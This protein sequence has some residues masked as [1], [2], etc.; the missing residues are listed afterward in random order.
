MMM[1]MMMM[2]TISHA[3]NKLVTLLVLEGSLP[4]ELEGSTQQNSKVQCWQN[5]EVQRRQNCKVQG[6]Q[7]Y[8]VQ[9]WQNSKF[10]TD[11]AQKFHN[12]VKLK[13]ESG[14]ILNQLNSLS[15][16]TFPCSRINMLQEW[17]VAVSVRPYTPWTNEISRKFIWERILNC[18]DVFYFCLWS[19]NNKGDF[20]RK[21][22]IHFTRSYWVRLVRGR[23]VERAGSLLR[24]SSSNVTSLQ[25]W[26]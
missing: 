12:N 4:T 22:R 10:N 15:R 9:G 20:I 7:N 1:M 21:P 8:K 24:H 2:N 3:A 17:S 18:V 13:T 23:K 5:S 6:W 11:G 25:P 19:D 14:K 16:S 26:K